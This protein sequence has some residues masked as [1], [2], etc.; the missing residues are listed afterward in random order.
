MLPLVSIIIPT[1]NRAEL[2]KS[3]LNSVLNQQYSFWECIIVDDGSQD[4]TKSIAESYCLKDKRFRFYKRPETKPKGASACRNYG[5]EMAKGGLIQFLD[6][7][8]LLH[9]NKLQEQVKAYSGQQEL[10]TCKWGG[11]TD[12]SDFKSR[13][14]YKYNSYRNFKKGISLLNTFGLFDEYFPPIV[15]LTPRSLILKSGLWNEE[16]TNNDDA[17]FFT[18]IILSAN[19]I[20]FISGATAYYRY[21]SPNSLSEINNDEKI[22]SLVK[23]INSIKKE[24]KVRNS[25]F[26][27]FYYQRAKFVLFQYLKQ[28]NPEQILYYKEFLEERNNFTSYKYKILKKIWKLLNLK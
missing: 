1:F 14:K 21:Y 19:S 8:D 6:D 27:G 16:I 10:L 12:V 17:E 3:T 20:R 13:F 4:N 23:S 25:Y 28:K 9:K 15:Y 5:F 7:D 18:R 26:A 2:I 24:I 22:K 11:F